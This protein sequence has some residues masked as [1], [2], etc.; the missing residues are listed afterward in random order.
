[1][2]KILRFVILGAVVVVIFSVLRGLGGSYKGEDASINVSLP[3]FESP[4]QFAKEFSSKAGE[5]VGSVLGGVSDS[6]SQKVSDTVQTKATEEVTK[7]F[8][9][10]SDK[11]KEIIKNAICR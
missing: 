5:I 6:I 1:M 4:P 11:E 8:Q 10:L 3:G 9:N 2:F 7:N